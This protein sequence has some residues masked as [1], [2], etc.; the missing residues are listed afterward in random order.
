MA[1]EAEIT[2]VRMKLGESIPPDGD[3]DDTLFTNDQITLWIDDTDTLN[4][5]LVEGWEAKL[6]HWANLV[7]VVD[8]AAARE[9]SDLMDHA[10][11]MINHYREQILGPGYGRSRVGKIVRTP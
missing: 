4:H 6:A 9:F 2:S 11:Y 3:E 10:K 1:T 8:G 5:A 7:N